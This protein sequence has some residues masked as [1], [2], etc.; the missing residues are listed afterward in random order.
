MSV[1][2]RSLLIPLIGATATLV[3]ANS[4]D[5]APKTIG[6]ATG[7]MNN[8]AAQTVFQKTLLS[9]EVAG[10]PTPGVITS[11]S[12]QA[13]QLAQTGP[14]ELKVARPAGN[15]NLR[16]IAESDRVPAEAQTPLSLFT[17]QVRIPVQAGDLIGLYVPGGIANFG[18][19]GDPGETFVAKVDDVDRGVGD[20]TDYGAPIQGV[21]DMSAQL[22]PDADA[23][24][25]GDDTQDQCLGESGQENGCAPQTV[26]PPVVDSTAPETAFTQQPAAKTKQRRVS[27]AFSSSEDGSS[28]EC[29][30]DGQSFVACTSPLQT[31]KL[32]RGKHTFQV[33]ATDAAGN[34]D[35]TPAVATFK[36]KKKRKQRH[37]H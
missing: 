32:K 11:W 12:Y 5:A 22:E 16:I 26:P 18:V 27:F 4:A 9:P 23:D 28:F 21:V 1:M 31:A 14:I 35:G 6:R 13:P 37:H 30:L 25:F 7:T 3:F 8:T 34:V 19:T 29:G 15:N 33:R 2:K 24:G 17:Q 10:A 20:I 36:V